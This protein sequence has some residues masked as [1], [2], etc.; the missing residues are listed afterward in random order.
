MI[1][2]TIIYTVGLCVV[3]AGAE[4]LHGT[5]R[6]ILVAPRIG[7]ER[8]HRLSIISGTALAFGICYLLVP[9]IGL[10]T[11]SSHL[12]LG[13]VLALFM[14]FFDLAMGKLLLR[15]TWSKAFRDFDPRTGNLLILGLVALVVIP[16]VVA[17][18]RGL[19]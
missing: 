9:G 4:T 6:T 3:L 16:T 1:L 18:L 5:A 15:R 7:K 2:D 13:L 10:R 14:A 8:A 11:V 12:A 17:W 19:V